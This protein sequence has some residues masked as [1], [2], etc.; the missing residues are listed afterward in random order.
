[1]DGKYISANKV[2]EFQWRISHNA[3]YTFI[4]L[5][6]IDEDISRICILCKNDE[7]DLEHLFIDYTVVKHFWEWIFREFNFNTILD[8]QFIYLNNYEDMTKLSFFITILGKCT[9]WEMRGILRKAPHI[10]IASGL[11]INQEHKL[12]SH[13]NTLYQ[14]YKSRNASNVF[15]TEFLLQNNTIEKTTDDQIKVKVNIN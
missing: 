4:R 10:N 14:I 2:K 13:L 3:L 11:K 9:I 5:H 8:K 12:Q 15:E 7:E 1:M 6:E